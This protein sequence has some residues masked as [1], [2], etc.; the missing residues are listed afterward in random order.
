MVVAGEAVLDSEG[1]VVVDSDVVVMVV[2][3]LR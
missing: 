3:G 1:V 2:S